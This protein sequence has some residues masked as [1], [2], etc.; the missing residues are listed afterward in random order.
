MSSAFNSTTSAMKA[1][2]ISAAIGLGLAITAYFMMKDAGTRTIVRAQT[3]ELPS[4]LTRKLSE[5][6]EAIAQP[7][8]DN[9]TAKHL[10][11]ETP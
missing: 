5:G 6:A 1:Q 10:R 8:G 9:T 2:P 3:G 11:R 4:R 7:F